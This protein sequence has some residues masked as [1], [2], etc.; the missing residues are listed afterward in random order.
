MARAGKTTHQ[1]G[2]APRKYARFY[3]IPEAAHA[4]GINYEKLLRAIAKGQG[5]A[6]ANIG[7]RNHIIEDALD[8]WVASL[9]AK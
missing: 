5:P 7:G 3:T 1:V 8:A 4:L 2:D 6:V 9:S